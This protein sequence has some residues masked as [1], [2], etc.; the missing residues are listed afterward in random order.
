MSGQA[1]VGQAVPGTL[2]S[3]N[4]NDNTDSQVVFGVANVHVD[5]VLLL[6]DTSKNVRK[7]AFVIKT[8]QRTPACTCSLLTLRREYS[9]RP[10]VSH[11]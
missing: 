4:D 7:T 1:M 11:P 3:G 10:S 5:A 2:V 8:A 6:K 9:E